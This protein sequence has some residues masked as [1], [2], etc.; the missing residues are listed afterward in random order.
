MKKTSHSQS[1]RSLFT[2]KSRQ[3][4]TLIELLVVIAIIAILAGMLLPALSKAREK[5][6]STQCLNNLKQSTTGMIFY[7]D[8]NQGLM[9]MYIEQQNWT[10]SWADALVI[11][12]CMA[13]R[14]KMFSCP[15][16]KFTYPDSDDQAL[17]EIYGVFNQADD[18]NVYQMNSVFLAYK[19]GNR[20]CRVLNLKKIRS[21]TGV[22]VLTDS[23][24]S[25]NKQSYGICRY[26]YNIYQH[27]RHSERINMSFADGHASG[28]A[29]AE[30][31][32]L[33][34]NNL[35]D[36]SPGNQWVYFDKNGNPIT[37][38]L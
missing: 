14:S 7:S 16:L 9:P 26:Q 25:N 3:H 8:S 38:N 36:Y 20:N 37:I 28:L 15:S 18:N 1:F 17:S 13:P 5:A 21:T 2:K 19:N 10:Y 31:A 11:E 27:A 30:V 34:K 23:R 35:N 32:E 12:K 22:V 24:D 4:F 6:H 29:P 33:Y